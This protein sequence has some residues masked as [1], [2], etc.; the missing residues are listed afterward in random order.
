M[1]P[2][3]SK[4]ITNKSDSTV[5]YVKFLSSPLTL[6]RMGLTETN[7][8]NIFY[9]Y[10]TGK[11]PLSHFKELCQEYKEQQE[12][13]S[14]EFQRNS[15]T[16]FQIIVDKF[17]QNI[18]EVWKGLSQYTIGNPA[19]SRIACSLSVFALT[20]IATPNELSKRTEAPLEQRTYKVKI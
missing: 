13:Q 7:M 2:C 14:K 3:E 5:E 6:N 12:F 8:H 15:D 10:K 9:G 4:T 16:S 1:Q 17:N 18:G 19:V 11:L 20:T